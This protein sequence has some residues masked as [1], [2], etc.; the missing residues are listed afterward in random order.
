MFLSLLNRILFFANAKAGNIKIEKRLKR[1]VKICLSLLL[2]CAGQVGAQPGQLMIGDKAPDIK[3]LEWIQGKPLKGYQKGMV[4]LI[5][6]GATWCTP[7]KAAIPHLNRLDKQYAGKA[8]VYSF[9]IKENQSEMSRDEYAAEVVERVRDY[10]ADMGDD[11]NYSV[12]V[13]D[14][15]GT[16]DKTWMRAIGK[17]GVPGAFIVDKSGRLAWFGHPLRADKVLAQVVN[18]QYDL[19]AAAAAHR[20]KLAGITPYDSEKPLLIG[21][22]GGEDTEFMYRSVMG[23]W[24]NGVKKTSGRSIDYIRNLYF[25]D[26]DDINRSRVQVIGFPLTWLYFMAYNDRLPLSPRDP[27]ELVTSYGKLWPKVVL[28]VT[29]PQPFVEEWKSEQTDNHYNYSVIVPKEKGNNRFLQAALRRDLE[30]YFGYRVSIEQRDMPVWHVRATDQVKHIE[31][32]KDKA[33]SRE[34]ANGLASNLWFSIMGLEKQ[35]PED[36]LPVINSIDEDTHITVDMNN[37]VHKVRKKGMDSIKAALKRHGLYLEKGT[38]RMRVIVVRDPE[39]EVH[40]L[41]DNSWY[42][43]ASRNGS[44]VKLTLKAAEAISKPYFFGHDELVW[45]N[46]QQWSQ[47]D[48]NGV[49]EVTIPIDK[50]YKGEVKKLGGVL[51]FTDAEGKYRTLRLFDTPVESGNGNN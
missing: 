39:P 18:D 2:V 51:A 20:D 8:S 5:E 14:F 43:S 22:N 48:E 38:H 7:C 36:T 40:A 47:T 28:E 1:S 45:R 6:F 31:N 35:P 37:D 21:G 32:G 16:L 41:A 11:M 25:L 42:V 26:D 24:K 9:F 15:Q 49:I 44:V 4:Y 19:N 12:G 46:E 29:D 34:I 17:S 23:K 10:V 3:V 33:Y 13:D 30:T 50:N 27:K